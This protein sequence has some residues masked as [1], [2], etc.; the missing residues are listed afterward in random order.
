MFFRV[1]DDKKEETLHVTK[2]LPIAIY[3]RELRKERQDEIPLHWHEE[4]QLVWVFTGTLRYNV[5]GEEFQLQQNEGILINSSKMHG[6]VPATRS[7]EYICVDFSPYFI[8]EAIYQQNIV[9]I[10]KKAG[11]SYA[12]LELNARCSEILSNMKNKHAQFLAVYELLISSLNDVYT[13]QN[14]SANSEKSTIY[15]LLDYVHTYFQKPLT[16]EDIAQVIPISKKKCTNLFH[17]YTHLSPINYLIEYRLNQARKMLLET[18]MDVSTI[19]FAVGFN[20]VSYFITKF[21]AKY[22]LTPFQFRKKFR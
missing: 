22:F 14:T 20:N 17:A 6:A 12:F 15:L 10:Q 2:N 1:N 9:E 3:H 16:V 19:C 7:S 13:N 5:E 8:N 11:F 18:E 4:F 21:K